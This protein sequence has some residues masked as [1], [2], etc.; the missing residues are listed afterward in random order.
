LQKKEKELQWWPFSL[1]FFQKEGKEK[2]LQWWWPFSLPFFQKEGKEKELQW[3]WPFSL[4]FFKEE[5]KK[6]GIWSIAHNFTSFVFSDRA[7]HQQGPQQSQRQEKE[8]RGER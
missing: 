1:P 6:L 3:W 5:E 4:A 8:K 7:C 2:E